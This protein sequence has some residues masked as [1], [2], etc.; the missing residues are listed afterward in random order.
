V[1]FAV[2]RLL[3]RQG[4]EL[5]VPSLP[6]CC[7]QPAF[8]AGLLDDARRVARTTLA[9]LGD[10]EGPLLVPSGSCADML[11]HH[12]PGLFEPG[13]AEAE[14]ARRLAAR[15]RELSQFLVDDLGLSDLGCRVEGRVAYHPSCHLS[16]GLG[17]KEQPLAL[18]RA[19]R[20][21]ELVP[22]PGQEECCGFGGSF[23]VTHDALSGAML[24]E[25]MK[26][27]QSQAPDWVVSCDLG[28]LMHLEGGFRRKGWN[29]KVRHLAQYL[30]EGLP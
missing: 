24:M 14:A 2:A 9:A 10:G 30:A 16:R 26:N 1:G 22:F 13:T 6:L 29:P 12:L 15:T 23:S 7:G 19:V 21:A 20:G 17:V 11:S 8:N 3:G 4:W 28:C 27:L 5:D 25:K 18:L